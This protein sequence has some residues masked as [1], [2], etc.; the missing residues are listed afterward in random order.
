M[1]TNKTEGQSLMDNLEKLATF[2]T[3]D[4]GRRQTKVRGNEEWTIQRNWQ[5]WVHKTHDEDKQ[6]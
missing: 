5:H 3:Q 2:G 4:T 1:K 6:N